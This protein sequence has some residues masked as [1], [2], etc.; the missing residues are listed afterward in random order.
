VNRNG[1]VT[2]VDVSIERGVARPLPATARTA[3]P[4]VDWALE[5]LQDENV[6]E[7]LIG[8]LAFEQIANNRRKA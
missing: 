1:F 4:T 7:T 8:D 5:V 6:H 2:T 3:I